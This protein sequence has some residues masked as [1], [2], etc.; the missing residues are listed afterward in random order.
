MGTPLQRCTMS[1]WENGV[2]HDWQ[3]EVERGMA[4]RS[5]PE[6]GSS[7]RKRMGKSVA[8]SQAK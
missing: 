6:D 5:N 2:N 1:D 8:A 3:I 4:S 7:Q